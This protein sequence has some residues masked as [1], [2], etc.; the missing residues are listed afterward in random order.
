MKNTGSAQNKAE[1][2]IEVLWNVEGPYKIK[3]KKKFLFFP[4]CCKYKDIRWAAKIHKSHDILSC[5]NAVTKRCV[6]MCQKS[7][8]Y[9]NLVVVVVQLW[10]MLLCLHCRMQALSYWLSKLLALFPPNC[11]SPKSN[12][13]TLVQSSV[14]PKGKGN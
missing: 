2:E 3:N 8:Y 6:S 14:H 7:E 1:R 5:L 12:H 11:S 4:L 10:G 9:A 13:S